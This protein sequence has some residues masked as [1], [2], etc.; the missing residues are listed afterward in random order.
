MVSHV[1]QREAVRESEPALGLAL[2]SASAPVSE[3]A[4]GLVRVLGSAPESE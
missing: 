4:S 2:A 1:S 3:Q